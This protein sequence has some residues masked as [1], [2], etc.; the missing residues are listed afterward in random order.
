MILSKYDSDS[1]LYEQYYFHS[2]NVSYDRRFLNGQSA[3]PLRQ[4]TH[5]LEELGWT[6]QDRYINHLK[7]L[8]FKEVRHA[9][10]AKL[11]TAAV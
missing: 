11:E 2:D 8:K 10:M 5:K 7:S 6:S 3:K 9:S 1:D 4:W